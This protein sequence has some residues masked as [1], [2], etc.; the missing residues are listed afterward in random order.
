M[1]AAG[2]MASATSPVSGMTSVPGRTV[3]SIVSGSP[4]NN[5][6]SSANVDVAIS[7]M[8]RCSVA[9]NVCVSDRKKRT[10]R[11]LSAQ[12]ATAA[13]SVTATNLL[14]LD[15]INDRVPI[16]ANEAVQLAFEDALL[17]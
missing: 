7:A 13:N 16:K 6:R 2:G 5:G 11:G 3:N 9:E 1:I 10:L 15:Q 12:P 4:G 17:I 8:S 14:G